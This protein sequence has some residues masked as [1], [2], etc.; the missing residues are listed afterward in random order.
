VHSDRQGCSRREDDFLSV[1]GLFLAGQ[2][3]AGR[4]ELILNEHSEM[5]GDCTSVKVCRK[6]YRFINNVVNNNLRQKQ[7]ISGSG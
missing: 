7:V 3:A 6:S 5:H 1:T 4:A 2:S